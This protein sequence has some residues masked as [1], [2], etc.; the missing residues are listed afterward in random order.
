[1]T[2]KA[3]ASE[4]RI[5]P[6]LA[7]AALGVVYGDIGT[8]P[9]YALQTAIDSSGPGG[10]TQPWIVM[11]VVSL[12]FWALILI[13]S[14]KYAILILRADNRGEGG[15]VALLAI[16]EGSGRRRGG[17]SAI[18]LVVGLVGAALLYGDGAITPAISVLSAIEGLEVAAPS[19]VKIVV[20]LTVVILLALFLMQRYGTGLIGR[21]FGPIM[22]LWFIAIGLLG[23]FAIARDPAIL[24]ALN[25][26]VALHFLLNANPAVS[27]A[28]LGA[29]F[30]AVTGGEAMYADM[31]HFGRNPIRLA[32]FVVALPALVLNYLGQGALLLSDPSAANNPFY[33]LV[34]AWLHFPII[35][36]ATAATVI[37][38][39]AIISG[40]FSLARQSMQLGLLPR[41][42]IKQTA[43][44]EFGQIYVPTVNWLL[45]IG[46]MVAVVGFGSSAALA[47]AY[48]IAVSLLMAITTLLAA[49]VA[50]QWGYNLFLVILVNGAFFIVDVIFVAANGI[51]L[52]EGG[53]Y[54]LLLAVTVAMLMLTWRR[55]Q[56]LAENAR[57]HLRV[58][59]T[60]FFNTMEAEKPVRLPGTAAFLSSASSGMPL[61]LSIFLRHT[62]AIPERVMLVT[63]ESA[64]IP[65]IKEED[66]VE[67]IPLRPDFQRVVLHFGFMEEPDVVRGLRLALQR[68][69]IPDVDLAR[70]SFYI[71]SETVIP[72]K[73]LPG[74][75]F[76]REVLYAML[77]RNAERSASYFRIPA[78]QVV[79][80]GAEIEI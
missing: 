20:P 4:S 40:A 57:R 29:A 11:G 73:K 77:Q 25:P 71:G 54:P 1:M 62:H 64:E 18:L 63:V 10:A 53:W 19:L 3:G 44:D 79:Q 58:E 9:L 27:F 21:L 39:Q 17:Q 14:L 61:S 65:R 5:S 24:M 60:T 30:L 8:S 76:W 13:V 28:V 6:S 12:I 16:L 2:A 70:M 52:F 35:I 15:I 55:G 37:A 68:G 67:I 45:C 78:T 75:A 74:M 22:L 72:A 56:I 49:L 41:L 31:G 66:R 46:T 7:L 32:W 26:F 59:E 43:H 48:G 80:L 47:G 50:R 36:F 42:T 34:P 69:L 23:A 33:N 51:K 38:S